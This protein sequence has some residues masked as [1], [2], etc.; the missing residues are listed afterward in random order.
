MEGG[1]RKWSEAIFPSFSPSYLRLDWGSNR[2][3]KGP[4][5]PLP[6]PLA[7][8]SLYFLL[9]RHSG[10]KHSVNQVV[11]VSA[12]LC[13]RNAV[14]LGFPASQGF[15]VQKTSSGLHWCFLSFPQWSDTMPD[16]E[17]YNRI[18]DRRCISVIWSCP[19]F[20]CINIPPP[21]KL[22]RQSQTNILLRLTNLE[23][24]TNII[25]VFTMPFL[26]TNL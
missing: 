23:K 17:N 18:F 16:L 22:V 24:N 12:F 4:S 7:H 5:L 20:S 6:S 8:T 9:F 19:P 10:G 3:L 1:G 13:K 15:L 21:F 14:R 26:L 11:V 25:Q 2:K